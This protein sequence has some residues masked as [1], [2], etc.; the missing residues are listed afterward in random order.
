MTGPSSELRAQIENT[1]RFLAVDAVV[2]ANS[3]HQGAPMGLAGPAFELW[4]RHLRFDPTDP[5]WPLRDRF[6]LSAGHASMLLYALLH[7]YG[8]D[9]SLDDIRDFRQLG[10]RTPGHPEYGHTPGVEVTTGPLG[11]GFGHGVGM[12]LAARMTRAR[13]GTDPGGPGHH[14]VYGIVSDGD[15]ME[16][17]SYEA[18]S[19]A[20][21]LG[22]GNLVYLYDDNRVTIDGSTDLAFSEDVAKRFE[23]ARWHVKRVEEGDVDGLHKALEECKAELERPSL[24]I[25]RTTIGFGSPKLAGTAPAHG[26]SLV[27]DEVEATKR[28]LGWP[29]EPTFLVPEPVRAY[30]GE[31]AAAK[32]A[33][34]EASDTALEGWR[35]ANPELAAEW[36]RFRARALPEDLLQ[37]L[38]DGMDGVAA[39]TRKHSGTVI[40]KLAALA[41]YLVGGSADLAGSNNT[42]I[43]GSSAVAPGSFEGSNFHFGVREHAMGAITNGVALDGTFLPYAGTFLIFSDYVRPSL[44]LAALMGVKSIFVFTH[45]SIFVGEDGPTHQPIEHVDSLRAMP[46]LTLFRPADGVET[47]A[48]WAWLVQHAKGPGALALTRQGTPALERPAGFDPA[49]VWKGAYAVRES[50][51]PDVVLVATGSEVGLCCD[52]A[53]RLADEGVAARVVS[54]P[55]LELFEAQPADWRQELIPSRSVPVVA[56]EA[57]RGLTLRGLVGDR[58]RVYGIDRFGASAPAGRMAE[59]YGFVPTALASAVL[60]HLAEVSGS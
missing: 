20:G 49:L 39:A 53:A 56:V 17:V 51:T 13:F 19:L 11:Q 9:L 35:S 55:C 36:A 33:E 34:R 57:A 28:N 50:A 60:E 41:P 12:A 24:V 10:S 6:V 58:G 1:I 27:G 32:R 45:D 8:Y 52:A 5:D 14:R 42:D 21:H 59:E 44:R 37:R 7:L 4:D 47:A 46:G 18:A 40:N 43:D 38:A 15:L 31:R 22:L 26:A 29:L 16:G 25:C 2:E 3:G 30:M 48:A 54:L 23:G